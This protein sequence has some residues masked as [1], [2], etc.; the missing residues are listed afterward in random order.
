MVN[1][2]RALCEAYGKTYMGKADYARAEAERAAGAN[3]TRAGL[4]TTDNNNIDNGQNSE[5]NSVSTS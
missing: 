2:K 1:L 3:E 4:T 5:D